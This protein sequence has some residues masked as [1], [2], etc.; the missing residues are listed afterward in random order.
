MS[1]IH[2][3]APMRALVP[4]VLSSL[5]TLF[6]CGT[7]SPSVSI[8]TPYFLSIGSVGTAY[9]YVAHEDIATETRVPFR[10]V[11]ATCNACETTIAGGNEVLVLA[12]APGR[13]ELT[14]TI[15]TTDDGER[16]DK[17][18]PITFWQ[19]ETIEVSN[20]TSSL[21]RPGT[22]L[23]VGSRATWS[24]A[25]KHPALFD[26]LRVSRA[27]L[28]VDVHGDAVD[29]TADTTINTLEIVA[30][31]P[32][33]AIVIVGTAGVTGALPPRVVGE[34][35]VIGIELWV[36][37][38]LE[39]GIDG[40]SGPQT[41]TGKSVLPPWPLRDE[42]LVPVLRLRDGSIA[43][44]GAKMVTFEPPELVYLS[45]SGDQLVEIEAEQSGRG[46]LRCAIGNA[47]LQLE[48]DV[49]VPSWK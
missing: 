31:Q 36:D 41:R 10:I 28:D 11:A 2:I 12:K 32:G 5:L 25:A 48:V 37:Y 4:F 47:S 6:G 18:V 40:V 38:E 7:Q 33:E 42:R 23:L 34:Q 29:V 15:E 26:P 9:V 30:K 14:I 8:Q 46:V 19:P 17:A 35:D 1:S 43:F 13:T 44:G 22:G 39:Q 45:T 21:L 3:A 16:I 49:E 24:F 27:A 20:G